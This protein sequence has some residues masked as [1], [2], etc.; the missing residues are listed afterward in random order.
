MKN[1]LNWLFILILGFNS[2]G[3]TIH[4]KKKKSGINTVDCLINNVPMTFIFDT[5]SN[6]VTIS[7]L[8]ARFMLKHGFLDTLDIHEPSFYMTASGEID[9]CM[10]FT[11]RKLEINGIILENISGSI[12]NNSRAPLLFGMS[13]IEKLGPISIDFEKGIIRV[14]NLPKN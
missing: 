6:D 7:R 1:M 10:T 3:Q 9:T 4:L 12:I 5:G 13:A 8:E 14:K 2:Y 11:I